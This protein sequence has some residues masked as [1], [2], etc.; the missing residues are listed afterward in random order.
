MRIRT[1]TASWTA[2][3]IAAA[4]L[5]VSTPVNAEERVCRTT[6]GAI[7]LDNVRVP[8][9][10]SCTLMR[11]RVK[12]TIKVERSA[13]LRAEGV[14]VIGNVEGEGAR[15]VMVLDTSRVGGSVKV[16][17]GGSATVS[18]SHVD[19]NILYDTNRQPVR[20]RSTTVGGDVQAFQN[21]GGVEIRNNRIDGNLQCKA[22][23]PAPIGGNNVVQG[24]KQDQC[25]RL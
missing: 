23:N 5:G 1:L 13:T 20:V 12:G 3:T 18:N 15:N 17:Q 19:D 2:L 4:V 6:I 7:T 9:N 10:A 8:A 11:T 25:S 22:N 14:V 24:N 21:R 16:V